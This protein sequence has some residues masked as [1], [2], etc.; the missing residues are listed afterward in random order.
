MFRLV[1]EDPTVGLD[2]RQ[3]ARIRYRL[4]EFVPADRCRVR[5]EAPVEIVVTGHR[6]PGLHL[7]LLDQV[8]AIA[9]CRFR[10]TV[11]DD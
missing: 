6:P 3:A 9:G 1:A 11:T 10:V 8:E 7:P 4:L 2:E 5:L